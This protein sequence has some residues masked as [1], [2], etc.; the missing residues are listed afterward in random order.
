MKITPLITG[1]TQS[2][3]YYKM[4]FTDYRISIILLY[5]SHLSHNVMIVPQILVFLMIPSFIREIETL[6]NMSNWIFRNLV[7]HLGLIDHTHIDYLLLWVEYN[8]LL[9]VDM[10][11]MLVMI[12]H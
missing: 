4:Y 3:V 1:F 9:L 12:E 7:H 6:L 2:L 8:M 5:F 11:Y 10:V